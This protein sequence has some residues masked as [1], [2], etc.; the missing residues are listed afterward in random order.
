MC[1]SESDDNMLLLTRVS[2][3]QSSWKRSRAV[4]WKE[5]EKDRGS[6]GRER[7]KAQRERE[8]LVVR[9]IQNLAER[10]R[11]SSLH[12]RRFVIPH[13][14]R[15]SVCTL[16]LLRSTLAK[17]IS[18][19]KGGVTTGVG[20]TLLFVVNNPRKQH[21]PDKQIWT[22]SREIVATRQKNLSKAHC[23]KHIKFSWDRTAY[24][25]HPSHCLPLYSWSVW[26]CGSY[27]LGFFQ[28]CGLVWKFDCDT[29]CD[30]DLWLCFWWHWAT[31]RSYQ[32]FFEQH[33]IV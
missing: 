20:V 32:I 31:A 29:F 21:C 17:K 19:D 5:K 25:F 13:A 22:S 10:K 2:N 30:L 23:W 18:C 27:F 12:R 33:A 14:V 7:W 24:H 26:I 4:W 15:A 6:K 28:Y 1:E 3:W 9:V 11:C 16:V 8:R